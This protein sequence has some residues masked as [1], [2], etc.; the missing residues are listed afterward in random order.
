MSSFI[1]VCL[2]AISANVIAVI[3]WGQPY[4]LHWNLAR[5][6]VLALPVVIWLVGAQHGVYWQLAA[7]VLAVFQLRLMLRHMYRQAMEKWRGR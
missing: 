2:W 1:A 4:R 3:P 6:L 5:L 7:L